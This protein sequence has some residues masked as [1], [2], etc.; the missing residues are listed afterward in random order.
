MPSFGLGAAPK[1]GGEATGLA[2]PP[3]PPKPLGL[4]KVG[5]P[6]KVGLAPKAGVPPNTGLAPNPPGVGCCCGGDCG[7]PKPVW[8]TD[9]PPLAWAN[10]KPPVAGDDC[11]KEP[12]PALPVVPPPKSDPPDAGVAEAGAGEPKMEPP[13]PPNADGCDCCGEATGLENKLPPEAGDEGCAAAWP[14]TL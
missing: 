4:P 11:E 7:E 6:P 2:P 13:P 12:N 10:P 9:P 14:K 8:A 1:A 3:K 5:A